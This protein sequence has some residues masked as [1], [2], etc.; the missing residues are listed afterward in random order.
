MLNPC[1]NI[2]SSKKL[3]FSSLPAPEEPDDRI[4]QRHKRWSWRQCQCWRGERTWG[5]HR[6]RVVHDDVDLNVDLD[7]DLSVDLNVD[8][9]VDLNDDL[10]VD[11]NDDLN[12]DLNVDL[13]VDLSVHLNVDLSVDLS[14]DLNVD[15]SVD[16]SDFQGEEGEGDY[17]VYECPGLASTDEMEVKNP[18]FNDDPTPKNPWSIIRPKGSG[19]KTNQS[20][21][22]WDPEGSASWPKSTN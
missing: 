5:D 3:I 21:P 17:T 8:L 1:F 10:S 22:R 6:I 13:I 4:G 16:Q 20:E 9:S 11:L 2:F 12:V 19:T 18:L 15:L 7:V 14:V